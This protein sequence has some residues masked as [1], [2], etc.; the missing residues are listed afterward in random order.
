MHELELLGQL[1]HLVDRHREL[2]KVAVRRPRVALQVLEQQNVARN[3]LHRHDQVILE[4]QPTARVLL[5]LLLLLLEL[6]HV[7]RE[8]RI[9][10]RQSPQ[11]RA[12]RREALDVVNVQPQVLD[13]RQEH[14]AHVRHGCAGRADR[15]PCLL[16]VGQQLLVARENHANVAEHGLEL[17]GLHAELGAA[18][19]ER[20]HKVVH[21]RLEARHVLVLGAEDLVH[22]VLAPCL[23]LAALL[24]ADLHLLGRWS[25]LLL[26]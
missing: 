24:V 16:E 14:A 9:G 7:P 1:A 22:N 10:A 15:L 4:R 20:L 11:H 8:R 2:L 5:L 19:L 13:H 25:L 21:D 3:A 18:A 17:L 26:R 6:C 23:H 12:R